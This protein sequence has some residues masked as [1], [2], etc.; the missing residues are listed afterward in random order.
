MLGHWKG[1]KAP[2]LMQLRYGILCAVSIFTKE[3]IWGHG[4]IT[5]ECVE[6]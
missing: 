4:M 1:E 3:G 5:V 6:V 2:W